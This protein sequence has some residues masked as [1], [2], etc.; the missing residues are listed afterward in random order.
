M[1]CD[2]C[3]AF[4]LF[5]PFHFRD[6]TLC[7]EL[8]VWLL[9][10]LYNVRCRDFTILSLSLSLSLSLALSLSL[11]VCSLPILPQVLIDCPCGVQVDEG[12]M[13][14]CD[15]C[16]VST[17]FHYSPFHAAFN[18]EFLSCCHHMW[19]TAQSDTWKLCGR[20]SI[21]LSRFTAP[22]QPVS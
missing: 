19:L 21:A 4:T 15:Q 14:Q 6:R 18:T 12:L 5:V 10:S 20:R 7:R 13:V 22:T 9:A 3:A 16:L 2:Q 1:L 11:F 8:K 17:H